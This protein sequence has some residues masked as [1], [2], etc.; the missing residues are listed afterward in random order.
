M[1]LIARRLNMNKEA[2]IG[3]TINSGVVMCIRDG[4]G[5]E[6]DDSTRPLF[7]AAANT[8]E[9]TANEPV[10]A[11]KEKPSNRISRTPHLLPTP[12]RLRLLL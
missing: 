11:D 9:E 7:V 12:N 10:N 4:A 6:S 2:K 5:E 1:T 8:G 3:F